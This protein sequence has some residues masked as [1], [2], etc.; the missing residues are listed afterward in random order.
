MTPVHIIVCIKPVPDPRRWSKLKLDPE[1]M[2]LE[3]SDLEPVINPLDR[4][5][6]E[7][8]L[9]LK[10]AQKATITALTMAPP[11]AEEQLKEALATGC[12]QA[13]LLTDRAF[14]GADTLATAR[15]LAAAIRKI[16]IFDLIFCGGYSL[17][18]STAQLGPQIAALLELPDLTHTLELELHKKTIKARCRRDRGQVR[19]ECD[20][21]ALV[22]FDQQINQPRVPG[23]VGIKRAMTISITCWDRKALEL[24]A[25]QVG[26]KGSPTRML[27]I[28]SPDRTKKGEFLK[29]PA[30]QIAAELV[31]KLQQKHLLEPEGGRS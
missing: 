16:G 19:L 6:L 12:D 17:D 1:T 18:G 27:S 28:F 21:P 8:A 29:G 11:S 23:M 31:Q 2:L 25:D 3:R 10:K 15:C 20:L 26:L 7:Q 14:A 9:V 13:F 4:N 22:T 30:S 24:E 5:A